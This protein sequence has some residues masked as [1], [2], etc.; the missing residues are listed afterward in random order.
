MSD[1]IM[2]AAIGLLG[3][4]LVAAMLIALMRRRAV[5]LTRPEL[6]AATLMSMAVISADKEQFR[7]QTTAA[8]RRLEIN[9][10]QLKARLN[11]QSIDANGKNGAL[12]QPTKA[13]NGTDDASPAAKLQR[14]AAPAQQVI[15]SRVLLPFAS[16]RRAERSTA[17]SQAELAKLQA[18]LNDKRRL[19]G[20][21]EDA[22][23]QLRDELNAVRE[24]DDALRCTNIATRRRYVAI[25]KKLRLE[26]S[27]LQ[28]RL[29]AAT[30][31]RARL[32]REGE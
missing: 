24:T 30:K 14:G 8:M 5:R 28:A 2:H 6:P 15:R 31:A 12:Q 3:A 17:V 9:V 23:K 11:A 21:R 27:D 16:R 13:L 29:W 1:A 20:E 4:A 7:A 18:E 19:L 10:A 32:R 25:E 26:I 22:I